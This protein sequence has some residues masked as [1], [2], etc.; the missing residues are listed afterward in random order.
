MN[1]LGVELKL[2]FFDADQIE[3]YEE[4]NER[5]VERIKEPSQ[6][7]GKSTADSFRI[8]CSI[9]N[10]FF[11]AV[12]GAGTS[13]KLFHGKNNLKDHMEAF[14]IVAESAKDSRKDL[15][16]VMNKYGSNRAERRLHNKQ[17]GKKNF[18][19]FQKPNKVPIRKGGNK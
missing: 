17:Q 4:E 14:G 11:D 12:F 2:D 15:D 10:D 16:A 9:I 6:Y 3:V 13:E 7:E 1:V 19:N 8:Q 5:V 18:Q